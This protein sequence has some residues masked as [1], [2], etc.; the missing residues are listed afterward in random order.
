MTEWE[1]IKVVC[2]WCDKVIKDAP[3]GAVVSHG[4]CP[5]CFRK[6]AKVLEGPA[7]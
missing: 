4:I 7:A 6:V 1:H 2:A 3:E 5:E